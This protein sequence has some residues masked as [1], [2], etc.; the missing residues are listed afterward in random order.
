[1]AHELAVQWTHPHLGADVDDQWLGTLVGVEGIR[2]GIRFPQPRELPPSTASGPWT[3]RLPGFWWLEARTDQNDPS[4]WVR[5][6]EGPADTDLGNALRIAETNLL[7]LFH[8]VMQ[9]AAKGAQS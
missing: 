6:G 7:K 8:E 3:S 4:K 5:V 2:I 1:M 9:L